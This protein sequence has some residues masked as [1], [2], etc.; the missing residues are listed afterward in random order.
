MV[1]QEEHQMELE[2]T[3]SAESYL[4]QLP[5]EERSKVLHAVERLSAGWDSLHNGRL[6]LLTGDQG[7]LYSLRVGADLRVIV[8]RQENVILVID[9][10]RRSQIDGL[11]QLA[12]Q[13]QAATG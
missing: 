9:V 10:V 3:F 1:T 11:R 2:W 7:G 6:T 12:N 5:H 13:R 4:D 8:R